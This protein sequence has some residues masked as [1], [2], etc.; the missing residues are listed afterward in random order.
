[1]AHYNHWRELEPAIAREAIARV[2]ETGAQ[3][4]A[5][6]PLLAHINELEEKL[7]TADT[8]MAGYLKKIKED[9]DAAIELRQSLEGE[10]SRVDGQQAAPAGGGNAGDI[11]KLKR[12]LSAV[13][14]ERDKLSTALEETKDQVKELSEEV[15]FYVQKEST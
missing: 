8:G 1:M 11:E 10:L 7:G 2:R 12:R 13:E 3:I 14:E 4:R 15:N 5:P 9:V 6:G